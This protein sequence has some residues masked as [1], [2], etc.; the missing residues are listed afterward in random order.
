MLQAREQ[1]G[2]R[3]RLRRNSGIA[4]AAVTC[5]ALAQLGALEWRLASAPSRDETVNQSGLRR[6]MIR[7]IEAVVARPLGLDRTVL[8]DRAVRSVETIDA[9]LADL[10]AGDAEIVARFLSVARRMDTAAPIDSSELRFHELAD[11]T[12]IMFDRK[13]REHVDQIAA[14]RTSFVTFLGLTSALLLAMIA[15]LY[16]AVLRRRD[17][18]LLKLHDQLEERRERFGAIFERSADMMTIYTTDGTIVRGN[19]AGI[20]TLGFDRDAVGR[21]YDIHIAPADLPLAD[22][23]FATAAAGNAQEFD[24]TFLTKSGQEIPVMVSIT[25]IVVN[26]KVVGMLGSARD[27]R[28]LRE[29]ETD[30]LQSRERFRSLFE[31]SSDAICILT[32]D[33]RVNSVNVA[34]ERLTGYASEDVIGK[35]FLA[36]ISPQRA[37]AAVRRKAEV[38]RGKAMRFE[39]LLR[40]HD[41]RDIDVTIDVS[42][43][44]INGVLDGSFLKMTDMSREYAL[45]RSIDRNDAR[46]RALYRLLSSPASEPGLVIDQALLIGAREFGMR[47]GF[48]TKVGDS[49]FTVRNRHGEGTA[50]AIGMQS[51]LSQSIGERIAGSSRAIAIDDLSGEPFVSELRER[52]LRWSCVIGTRLS[53]EGVPYGAVLFTSDEPRHE[54]FNEADFDFIE[55]LGSVISSAVASEAR[56]IELADSSRFFEDVINAVPDPV[57][58]RDRK[59]RW[60]VV[61]N[62]FCAFVG[63]DRAAIVGS[64]DDSVLSLANANDTALDA[65]SVQTADDTHEAN[66]ISREVQTRQSL[67]VDRAGNELRIGIIRDVSD[68]RRLQREFEHL[69]GTD[70]LTGVA[71]RRRFVEVA[72]TEIERAER[73]GSQTSVLVIDIDWFKKINDRFGHRAGDSALCHVTSVVKRL[74]RT[75]DV[76]GRIGGEEFA[77]LLPETTLESAGDAAERLR[78][79]IANAPL[80]G[81]ANESISLTVSI[82]VAEFGRPSITVDALLD[83]A[84]G[85][86][87]A[88]KRGG[89]NTVRMATHA[90]VARERTVGER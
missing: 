88:A 52:D 42:P 46:L 32:A 50:L 67:H 82:G 23:A 11:I 90:P 7:Q 55:L 53:V 58:V 71:N 9:S 39:T 78:V 86:L 20:E 65:Q 62:A 1:T 63:R 49:S 29:A 66:G 83:D 31:Q 61:N 64:T 12:F 33:N 80:I 28:A 6:A 40:N 18:V 41:G 35:D 15:F 17:D 24:A 22:R 70:Y 26:G 27:V 14:E 21:R 69:A 77:V 74:L 85:A 44:M 87:Y 81:V 8:L 25:P 10:T 16:Y 2:L 76:V 48:V 47:N 89:R 38:A 30:V 34:F 73:Y 36:L 57:F 75:I 72:Q 45:D 68:M 60:V 5:L 13:T 51:Q 59:K 54:R 4:I 37:D 79:G 56:A 43:I 3:D 19:R 84:D